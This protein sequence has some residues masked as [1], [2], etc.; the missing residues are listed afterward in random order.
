MICSRSIRSDD[1]DENWQPK[2]FHKIKH[3]QYDRNKLQKLTPH[4]KDIVERMLEVD[5]SKRLSASE[6]LKHPWILT[7]PTDS[8]LTSAHEKLKSKVV[9]KQERNSL[10]KTHSIMDFLFRGRASLRDDEVEVADS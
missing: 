2:L 5:P 6:A 9:S 4:G 8:H 3:G 1:D 7:T 10:Y